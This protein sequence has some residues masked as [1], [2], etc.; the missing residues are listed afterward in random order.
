TLDQQVAEG[1]GRLAVVAREQQLGR[2]RATR[3]AL[4]EFRSGSRR[5][6]LRRALSVDGGHVR[7][8]TV[9]HDRIRIAVTW[10]RR[11]EVC[12]EERMRSND[13]DEASRRLAV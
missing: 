2:C 5:R 3:A 1:D 8:L 10:R 12:E 7:L 6:L 13:R 4:G 11:H 9:A